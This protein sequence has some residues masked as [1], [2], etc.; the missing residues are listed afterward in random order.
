MNNTIFDHDYVIVGSG[1]GGSVSALRLAEKGWNVAV[2]EQGRRIG[3]KEIEAGKRNVFKLM[4]MPPLR[5]RGYFVQHTFRHVAIV[6][7]VGVGGGSIVWAA[8]MLEPKPSFYDDPGLKALGLD[9]KSELAPH[10]ATAR[11]ML[12]VTINPRQTEQDRY[13]RQTAERMGVAQTFGP[14]P[15]AVYFGE[16]GVTHPD[17]FFGGEGPARQGCIFCGGC[18]TGCPS[19]AKNSLDLN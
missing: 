18:M 6:G 3:R 12:G 4:W 19:G 14:V 13:L 7:G 17:P 2:V 5:M 16:P 1:F 10:L 9:L 11:R 8:V 15:N